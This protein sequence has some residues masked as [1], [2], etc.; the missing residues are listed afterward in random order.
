MFSSLVSKG[1]IIGRELVLVPLIPVDMTLG[2][3]TQP[4]TM[5][6]IAAL[7]NAHKAIRLTKEGYLGPCAEGC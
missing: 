1:K 3:H 6:L 5:R 4:Y 2:T 7:A